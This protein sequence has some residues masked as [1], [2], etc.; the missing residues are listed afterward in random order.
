MSGPAGHEPPPA[1]AGE[2]EVSLARIEAGDIPLSAERRLGELRESGGSYT[3][4]LSIADLA[5]CGQAGL[6]P[7]SQVMGSSIYQVGYQGGGYGLGAGGAVRIGGG[8]IMEL[9]T[10]SAAWNN[11]RRLALGRLE[12]EARLV[13]A[14][15]VIGV[16]L[17][18]GGRD[19]GDS[20]SSGM[21]EF[22]LVGTAVKRAGAVDRATLVLTELSVSDYV[23]LVSAGIEPAGIVGWSSAFFATYAFSGGF[24]MQSGMMA[25]GQNFELRE[26]TQG[27]YA[28]REQVMGR[29]G[30][31]AERLGAS[32]IV[33]VR[34]AHSV[35]QMGAGGGQ[36][37][38]L[39]TFH[40]IGTAVHDRPDVEPPAP[41]P[42]I[43]VST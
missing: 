1:G 33:G 37:G 27:F 18:T 22:S 26:F 41:K 32:G 5:L 38:L 25:S 43:D 35:G 10:L 9:E 42:T 8:F 28:A 16:E 7:V 14:D 36:T 40:A 24:G 29:M 2:A 11:A 19:A 17:R 12:R 13:G 31:Q 6:R 39:A 20:L 15:A 23:K 30:E 34:L 3:S 21:I 4:D